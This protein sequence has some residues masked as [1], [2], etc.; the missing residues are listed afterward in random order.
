MEGQ[1]NFIDCNNDRVTYE[2]PLYRL[3]MESMKNI[4][5]GVI[6]EKRK[7]FF[8]MVCFVRPQNVPSDGIENAF[9]FEQVSIIK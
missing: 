2:F 6:P 5:G 9:M 4:Q 1:C 7:L 8:K 3:H